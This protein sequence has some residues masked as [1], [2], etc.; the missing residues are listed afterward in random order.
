MRGLGMRVVLFLA[1]G[2]MA[3]MFLGGCPEKRTEMK[4]TERMEVENLAIAAK[5]RAV[6]FQLQEKNIVAKDPKDA[7]AVKR[8]VIAFSEGLKKRA[9]NLSELHGNATRG[10][11]GEVDMDAIMAL[12][13]DIEADEVGF[14]VTLPRLTH[15]PDLSDAEWQA[16]TE[17]L[18]EGLASLNRTAKEFR[19]NLKAY[20][21]PKKKPEEE[22]APKAKPA[23]EEVKIE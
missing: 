9:K 14:R 1:M 18:Q 15:G 3:L 22:K 21:A 19:D 2:M 10:K 8:W 13:A 7:D 11:L 12:I 17:T 16:F 4:E 5:A 6:Q 23:A 20:D